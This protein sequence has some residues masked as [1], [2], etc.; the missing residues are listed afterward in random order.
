MAINTSITLNVNGLKCFNQK[1]QGGKLEE[2]KKKAGVSTVAQQVK[3][4]T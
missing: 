3:N 2:K 4:P 1:T